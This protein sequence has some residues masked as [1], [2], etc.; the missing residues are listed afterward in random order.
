VHR[1]GY[2][3]FSVVVGRSDLVEP[4]LDALAVELSWLGTPREV[5]TLYFGGGTPTY[6]TPDQLGILAENAL[7]WHPL[8]SGYEWTVEANPA[9]LDSQRIDKLAQ[10]GVNR[11]SL[12]GQSFQAGKLKLLERDHQADHIRQA[13]RLAHQAGMQLSLD[14]IFSVPGETLD[15]WESDLEQALNLQPEHISTYGLT[16]ERGTA[17]WGRQRRNELIQLPQELQRDMYLMAIDRLVASGFDHYEVSNFALP[18]CRSRHNESYWLADG[19]YAAG[20]GAAR[21]VAGVRETNHRSTTTYLKRIQQGR[22]PIAQREKLDALQRAHERLIFGLR[23]LEGVHRQTF[24]KRCGMEL[25]VV[26]GPAI[27]RMVELGM[28]SDD[29]HCVQLTRAGLLVSDAIWPELL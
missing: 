28:L 5:D 25:D 8:A 2:C 17:Y 6:L 13:A 19:Y 1:C 21:Y 3:N 29:G 4:L 22:S 27:A 15:Q 23:R 9:D 16:I 11:L 18:G 14:L 12:G 10:L 20:P 24:Q 7:V 26:A